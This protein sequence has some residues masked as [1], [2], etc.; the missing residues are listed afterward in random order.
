[1]TSDGRLPVAERRNYT[2]VFNALYRICKE[3]GV[4]TLW[5]GGGPTVVRAM[6]VN[7]AQLATYSQS[8]QFILT[9]SYFDDDI[10]T[11]FT[12]SMISGFVTTVASL[13]LDI[14]KTRIQSMK[15][16][17]GKPEYTGSLDV[18]LKV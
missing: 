6:V 2:N 8:K 7:A 12:A 4:L 11:H 1:M 10:L 17:D 9:L 18:I 16:I 14:A 13:P 15:M 5:R 3:E